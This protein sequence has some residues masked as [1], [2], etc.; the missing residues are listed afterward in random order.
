MDIA[1]IVGVD[2]FVAG[3]RRCGLTPVLDCAVVTFEVEVLGGPHTGRLVPTGV[4]VP[5]LEAWPAVPPHWVHLPTDVPLT[6]TNSDVNETLFGWVRHSRQIAG[7]GD[8][9]EPTQ[10]WVAHVRGVL[11]EAA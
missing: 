10:A 7:W 11:A 2:G 4:G 9:E 5:E 1:S 8:A 6:R 3:L